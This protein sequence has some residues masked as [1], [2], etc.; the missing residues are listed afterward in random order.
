MPGC[1]AT[2]D[3]KIPSSLRRAVKKFPL[4]QRGRRQRRLGVA[5]LIGEGFDSGHRISKGRLIFPRPSD[6]AGQPPHRWRCPLLSGEL[7]ATARPVEF[8]QLQGA[9]QSARGLFGRT[10]PNPSRQP[11]EAPRPLEIFSRFHLRR[12]SPFVNGDFQRN[13]LAPST[14]PCFRSRRRDRSLD[15]CA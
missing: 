14:S 2:F 15:G 4:S 7:L 11:P 12:L 6:L 1:G 8:P 9:V 10:F 5:L 13:S 3:E